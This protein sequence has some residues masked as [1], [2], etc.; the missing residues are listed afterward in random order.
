VQGIAAL[1]LAG[2]ADPDRAAWTV[3]LEATEDTSHR[4]L[5]GGHVHVASGTKP[6]PRG[7]RPCP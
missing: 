6:A 4:V 7:R 5:R 2:G 1:R 3:L